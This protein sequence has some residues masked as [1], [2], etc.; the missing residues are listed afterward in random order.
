MESGIEMRITCPQCHTRC[1]LKDYTKTGNP[2]QGKC[3][4]C[5]HIFPIPPGVGREETDIDKSSGKP[6]KT[7]FGPGFK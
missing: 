2:S 5:G 3:P 6:K 7:G 1:R 4:G